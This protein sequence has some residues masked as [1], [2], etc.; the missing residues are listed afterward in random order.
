MGILGRIFTDFYNHHWMG[1]QQ[2]RH[3]EAMSKGGPTKISE[4]RKRIKQR[5]LIE[6]AQVMLEDRR[7]A[8]EEFVK[9]HRTLYGC[10]P[11]LDDIDDSWDGVEE[12]DG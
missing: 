8:H 1:V 3:E 4:V 11:D 10:D 5:D 12:D 2:V 7:V 6:I 9:I